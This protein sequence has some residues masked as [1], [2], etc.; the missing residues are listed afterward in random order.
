[1]ADDTQSRHETLMRT[2]CGRSLSAPFVFCPEVWQHRQGKNKEPADLVGACNNC[3]ILMYLTQSKIY[4]SVEKNKSEFLKDVEHNL[5]QAKRWMRDWRRKEIS[6]ANEYFRFG[7]ALKD[8]TR[9][10]VLS[11]VKSGVGPYATP[12]G[13]GFAEVRAE[14]AARAGVRRCA[15]VPQSFLQHL[16]A[17]GGSALDLRI[18]LGQLRGQGVVPEASTREI[19][20]DY[21]AWCRQV[22]D[23][24]KPED[25]GLPPFDKRMAVPVAKVVL[26]LAKWRPR[27]LAPHGDKKPTAVGEDRGAV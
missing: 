12:S 10:V 15:T 21:F 18:L 26:D 16:L 4:Q 11:I 22:S 23:D 17:Q 7:I 1:M 9:V 24:L 19:L 27:P 3:V 13:Q 6:G 8:T 20:R 5:T 14:W 25:F 2:F